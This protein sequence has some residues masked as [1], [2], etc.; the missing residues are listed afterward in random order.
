MFIPVKE[1]YT[2]LW[3]YYKNDR[4]ILKDISSELLYSNNFFSFLF[5]AFKVDYI[6]CWWWH[7]SILQIIIAKILRKK[8]I[9]TGAIHMYDYSGSKET[10]FKR[11]YIYR[12]IHKISL[13]LADANLFLTNDQKNQITSHIKVNNPLVVYSSLEK[14]HLDNHFRLLKIKNSYNK[15]IIASTLW[16]TESSIKRKGLFEILDALELLNDQNFI[17]YIIGKK[18]NGYNKLVNKIKNLKINSKVKI[19]TDVPTERK[20]KI[21]ETT[22][23]YLQPSHYEGLGN[24]VI[25]AMSRGCVPIVSRFASQPEVVGNLG[26]IVNEICKEEIANKILEYLNMPDDK[27][28]ILKNKILDYCHEKFSYNLHL[29]KVKNI[30]E[31]LN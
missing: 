26:Y 27:K 3:E 30:F 12:L 10:F 2:Q 24:S 28:D 20:F 9:C 19:F 17:F 16:L 21:L 22:N 15:T 11:N 25:E 5:S 14:K 13:Y 23:L 7:T 6:Y 29:K 1:S 8:I 18:G 4:D 31:S